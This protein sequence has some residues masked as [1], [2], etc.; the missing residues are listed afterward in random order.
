MLVK[1]NFDNVLQYVYIC[2]QASK[3]KYTTC[4]CVGYFR[5]YKHENEKKKLQEKRNKMLLKRNSLVN[6][7][8]A[9]M[10][11]CFLLSKIKK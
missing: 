10:R 2:S 4:V 8:I 7:D 9:G 3:Y 5:Y 11:K 1:I 6:D